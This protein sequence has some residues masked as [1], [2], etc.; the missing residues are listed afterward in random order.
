MNNSQNFS[1]GKPN[2][3]NRYVEDAVALTSVQIC[4]PSLH[5]F[6]HASDFKPVISSATRESGG[7][8]NISGTKIDDDTPA[9]PSDRLSSKLYGS[10]RSPSLASL[11]HP[12]CLTARQ[13]SLLPLLE[14]LSS[15]VAT[16]SAIESQLRAV[17]L[18]KGTQVR[19]C[20]LTVQKVS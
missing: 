14:D 18:A 17:L 11:P 2:T 5:P 1:D 15:I 13:A 10:G 3:A 6:R 8:L 16:Q 12:P 4:R 20:L 19:F 9:L 7:N